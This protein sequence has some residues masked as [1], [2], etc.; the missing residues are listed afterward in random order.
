MT[1]SVK[2]ENCLTSNKNKYNYLTS[3]SILSLVLYPTPSL[4]QIGLNIQDQETGARIKL[5]KIVRISLPVRQ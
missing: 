2:Q 4:S 3:V 5:L 1:I